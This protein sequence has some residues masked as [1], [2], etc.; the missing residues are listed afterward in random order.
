MEQGGNPLIN[1]IIQR[2]QGLETAMAVLKREQTEHNDQ[3]ELLAIEVH[4]IHEKVGVLE[5]KV[6]GLGQRVGSLEIKTQEF[7]KEVGQEFRRIEQK[8]DRKFDGV[9]K[10]LNLLLNALNISLT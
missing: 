7:R 4:H 10:K 5:G 6:D 2:Q 3:I 9:D 8:L 1:T